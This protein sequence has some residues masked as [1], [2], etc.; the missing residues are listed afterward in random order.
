MG[1]LSCRR[2]PLSAVAN[3]ETILSSN[4]GIF[5][6]VDLLRNTP[7]MMIIRTFKTYSTGKATITLYHL[8]A[9]F[10]DLKSFP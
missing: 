4:S 1:K 8:I 3:K 2:T 9:I 10:P 7:A 5:S 6:E